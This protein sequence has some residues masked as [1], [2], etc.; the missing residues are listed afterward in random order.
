MAKYTRHDVEELRSKIYHSSSRETPRQ[1]GL[2]AAGLPVD[3]AVNGA[4]S[5][6]N[7]IARW[8]VSNDFLQDFIR[9]EFADDAKLVQL[10]ERV[11]RDGREGLDVIAGKASA[12][13]ARPNQVLAG[14]EVIVRTDGS[15]PAFIV[16]EDDIV[17]D[18][19]PEGTW[20]RLLT[21]VARVP[22]IRQTLRSIGRINIKHPFAPFAGTGW[23]VGKSKDLI[24]TNRHVAQLFVDFDSGG[25]VMPGREA[26]VD[27]GHE[28]KG[29]K[30]RN[31]RA[32]TEL[33]FCGDTAIPLA[34]LNHALLDAAVFRL[35]GTAGSDQM[36]LQIG[37]GEHLANPQT[38]IVIIGYPAA[39]PRDDI[40]GTATETDRVLKLLFNKLW[41]YKRLA[42]GEIMV[43]AESTRMIRHDASTLG[44]NSGSL[45]MG[46][47]S[48][49]L[50]TGLH[51]GG[52][53]GNDRANCGHV[54]ENVLLEKGLSGLQYATLQ[55]LCV[56][57]GVDL[58]EA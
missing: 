11:L 50:V 53:W 58:V 26:Y 13:T 40:L 8:Q 46:L 49:P 1:G 35:D 4:T 23:L 12:T 45:I 54:I 55:E 51:Y 44:G 29:I 42:P 32:I 28:Y 9:R 37:V 3:E 38:Q 57:E 27:F 6:D 19:S 39:P 14:L 34:G 18:S 15:R 5:F 21:D 25:L 41:G 48:L 56:E 20:T 2:E 33:I 36:P 30:S 7:L 24:V 22:H 47:D 17:R 10:A 52:Y 16:R 31:R 43:G